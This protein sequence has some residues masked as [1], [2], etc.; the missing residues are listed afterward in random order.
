[1]SNPK[2]IFIQMDMGD[3]WENAPHEAIETS[4][5][6]TA[7]DTIKAMANLLE[8]KIRISY[9][10]TIN[11]KPSNLNGHYIDPKFKG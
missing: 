11:D 10:N 9:P 7:R 6:Q 2:L 5:P 8:R 3:G 1:M 4:D